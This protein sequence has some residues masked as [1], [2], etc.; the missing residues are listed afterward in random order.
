MIPSHWRIFTDT[1]RTEGAQRLTSKLQSRADR[2]FCKITIEDYHKGGHA[3][4]FDIFHEVDDWKSAVY[5]VI[6]CAQQVGHGWAISGF[7]DEEFELVSTGSSIA[8]IKLI[9]CFC[10]RPGTPNAQSTETP[11][12][13]RSVE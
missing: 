11:P 4:T 2:D 12:S 9:T 10:P 8:G 7:I 6:Q 5:D 13:C 1:N 3:V